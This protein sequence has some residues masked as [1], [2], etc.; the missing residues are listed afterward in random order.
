MGKK[1]VSQS[2]WE[3]MHCLL[4][5]IPGYQI[6]AMFTVWV[7]LHLF[8]RCRELTDV[9]APFFFF[10]FGRNSFDF[11]FPYGKTSFYPYLHTDPIPVALRKL[12]ILNQISS[13]LVSFNIWLQP[14][15]LT[16]P[17]FSP[18]D[19][20]SPRTSTSLPQSVS[21]P[22][23]PLSWPFC[24]G[25]KK[26]QALSP[27][28]PCMSRTLS[29]QATGR[30]A[31]TLRFHMPLEDRW[32]HLWATW[33]KTLETICRAAKL[34][35]IPPPDL[36]THWTGSPLRSAPDYNITFY[37]SLYPSFSFLESLF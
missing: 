8:V 20:A 4:Y 24:P 10:F 6:L 17:M 27:A 21:G 13:S 23:W 14:L 28:W 18:P 26:P 37:T 12:S 19:L 30:W 15:K 29:G 9:K 1:T 32:P 2:L 7:I 31:T 35:D 5:T 16:L 25:W 36:R 34:H 22:Q 11:L 3:T 33:L